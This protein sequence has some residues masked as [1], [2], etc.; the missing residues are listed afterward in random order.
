MQYKIIFV[1]FILFI[2]VASLCG[3][4]DKID[5]FTSNKDDLEDYF[6]SDASTSSNTNN[7]NYYENSDYNN[8]HLSN[9]MTYVEVDPEISD[10]NI[11]SSIVEGEAITVKAMIKN[12]YDYTAYLYVY[13]Y[14][15]SCS[16]PDIQAI[17][18]GS[19]QQKP[20]SFDITLLRSDT[21]LRF[22]LKED[23][24]VKDQSLNQISV[25]YAILDVDIE[26]IKYQWSRDSNDLPKCSVYI[27]YKIYNNGNGYAKNA[28]VS[29]NYHGKIKTIPYIYSN[30]YYSSYC[31]I[32]LNTDN[33]KGLY[34]RYYEYNFK[35]EVE[36]DYS[37]DYKNQYILTPF[38]YTYLVTPDDPIVQSTIDSIISEKAWYDIR[39]DWEYIKEWVGEHVDYSYDDEEE[40][41]PGGNLV[42]D[43]QPGGQYSQF[44]RETIEKGTG[45]CED[46]AIL[47]TSLLRAYG[48]DSDEVYVIY[49]DTSE[50]YHGWVYL[51]VDLLWGAWEQWS[52]I[53][54]TRDGLLSGYRDLIEIGCNLPMGI[55]DYEEDFRF[56]DEYCS[57]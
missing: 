53:E 38:T 44:A 39:D 52:Y 18:V 12:S 32:Y 33:R 9:S 48:Y 2:L 40:K 1:V 35:I 55:H 46:H 11:P 34:D 28:I 23:G 36:T 54:A 22:V 14:Y 27:Y 21:Y 31:V 42:G 25:Y 41:N 56:N 8:N 13:L 4:T 10:T 50:G 57:K 43:G 47:L 45:D 26:N 3:C 20:V 19:N 24:E 16:E 15:S 51:K 7:E 37:S 6:D 49:G 30:N 17:T 29:S 5:P